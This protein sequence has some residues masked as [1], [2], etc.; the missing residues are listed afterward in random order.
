MPTSNYT[1]ANL[2]DM[3]LAY[4]VLALTISHHIQFD[5]SGGEL[6]KLPKLSKGVLHQFRET[7]SYHIDLCMSVL[8][9]RT[10]QRLLTSIQDYLINPQKQNWLPV[11]LVLS[12]MLF[13]AESMQ[14][15][16]YLQLDDPFPSI[17]AMEDNSVKTLTGLFRDST[18]GFN[19]L[20]VDG[21]SPTSLGA[22]IGDMIDALHDLQ[23]LVREYGKPPG[24]VLSWYHHTWRLTDRFIPL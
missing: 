14:V 13:A 7:A 23:D 2:I 8:L 21:D 10:Q 22:N 4:L 19:S 3:G 20:A 15:D 1:Q 18:S 5:V 17:S 6:D 11:C 24:H 9:E 12:L 16:I